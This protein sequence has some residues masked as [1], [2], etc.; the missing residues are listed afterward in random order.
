MD[1]YWAVKTLWLENNSF[2]KIEGLEKLI[3]IRMLYLQNNKIRKIEGITHL[4]NLY[5][6]N[7]SGNM[8]ETLDN[9][10]GCDT[11]SN[12][13]LSTNKITKLEALDEACKLPSLEVLDLRNNHIAETEADKVLDYFKEKFPN[14]K[15]L[16]LKGNP[17]VRKI[18]DYRK[19]MTRNLPK[20]IYLD[21]RPI[22]DLE[23]L[24]A[25]AFVK[26]GREEEIRARDQYK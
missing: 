12:I 11:L 8:V 13:D 18:K 6:L 26:G 17:C 3:E 16:Y 9:L 14:I 5:H 23:R 10:E 25:N 19:W 2:D 4:K 15:A 21:D 7:I 1:E 24:L 22:T 20:L